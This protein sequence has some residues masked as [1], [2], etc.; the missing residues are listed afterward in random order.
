MALSIT[1]AAVPAGYGEALLPLSTVKAYL[2]VLSDDFDALIELLRDAGV[3]M[4]E[5]FT[6]CFLGPREGLVASFD[7]FAC[8]PMRLGR[9]PEMSL[10]VTG[11]S[12]IGSD[13]AAVAMADGSW[14]LDACGAL[15]PAVGSAWP[16]SYGP[17]TATF[18]AGF[19][20]G[21]CPTAL[22]QAVVMA[23]AF[24]FTHRDEIMGDGLEWDIPRGVAIMAEPYRILPMI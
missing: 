12:Y 17:V 3:D 14:V 18:D 15:V 23:T 20:E 9:G 4:V 11:L 24:I 16:T 1:P 5:K 21:E 8:V 6:S 22:L 13:G 7:G 19:A 2:G 10:S